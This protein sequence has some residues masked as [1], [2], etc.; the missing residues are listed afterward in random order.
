[1]TFLSSMRM[2]TRGR[3][4]NLAVLCLMIP[5]RHQQQPIRQMSRSVVKIQNYIDGR[6]TLP[7]GEHIDSFDPATGEVNAHVPDSSAADAELAVQA[8]RKAYQR[9]VCFQKKQH[10]LI[11]CHSWSKTSIAQRSRILN[12]I[13]NKIEDNLAELARLESQDQGKP[14]WQAEQIEIPRCVANLRHFG[15]A[16]NYQTETSIVEPETGVI[17]YTTQQPVGVVGVITPW[18]LP[19]YLLTFKLAPAIAYGNTVVAKPSEMTS[20]TAFRL[21]ELLQETGAV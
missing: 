18:N 4:D 5:R 1:M 17:N 11:Q 13:A 6:F 2:I 15:N 10:F 7:G 19:L 21:C 14:L 3:E 8:A 20:V 16:L 9:F 12:Q